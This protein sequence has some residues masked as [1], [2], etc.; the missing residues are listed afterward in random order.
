MSKP[1]KKIL[2]TAYALNPFKGSEDGMGWH[3]INQIAKNHH[4]VAI[5]RKN[6]QSKIQQYMVE[7]PTPLYANITFLYF[8]LPYFLRFWKKGSRGAMLYFYLWQLTMPLFILKKKVGFDIAHN[9][10]FHNDWTPSFLWVFGKPLA[11]GPVGHHPKIPKD[12]ILPLGGKKAFFKDR[13]RWALKHFF[14][15]LDPFLKLCKHKAS[16]IF[17]MNSSVQHVLKLKDKIQIMPSVASEKIE[18]NLQERTGFQVLSV[19]RFVPLKGFDVCICAFAQFYNSLDQKEKEQASLVL[20]GDG[21]Q[22]EALKQLAKQLEIAHVTT[23]IDWIE[24]AK[25][26]EYYQ[27]SRVFLFPSHEGAGM[28]VSEALSYG[29]PVI[30]FDNEGP[31]E[32]I[33]HECGKKIPYTNYKQSIKAFGLALKDYFE[34]DALWHKASKQAQIRFAYRFDW[35]VRGEQLKEA[36]ETLIVVND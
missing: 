21:P 30:A 14:W 3:F 35:N 2:A 11:W 18:N 9:L 5:T 10:N 24:R 33:T 4:V 22:K 25:L 34:N 32:F 27:S 7:N 20:I 17:A 1:S 16:V 13:L 23:F 28:V 29:L 31:G 8:D 19:G 6:N 36:Y 12:Y 26:K 15:K